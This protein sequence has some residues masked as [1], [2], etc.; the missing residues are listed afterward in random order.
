MFVAP[1]GLISS[2]SSSIRV[3]LSVGVMEEE[4]VVGF[5]SR[6]VPLLLAKLGRGMM[7]EKDE[8]GVWFAFECVCVKVETKWR[9]S[10]RKIK[11][12]TQ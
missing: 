1:G 2:S 4:V 9:T 5:L 7:G 8:F 6:T 3:S 11:S 10:K 12:R